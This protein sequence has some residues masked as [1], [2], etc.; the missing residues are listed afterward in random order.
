M[1]FHKKSLSEIKIIDHILLC[2]RRSA[3]I[4][5]V[6][7]GY[8]CPLLVHLVKVFEIFHGFRVFVLNIRVKNEN[9]ELAEGVLQHVFLPFTFAG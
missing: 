8:H 1:V 4:L 2:V 7:I 3:L 5:K 9:T 6:I